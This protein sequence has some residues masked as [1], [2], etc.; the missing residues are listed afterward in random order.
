MPRR[1]NNVKKIS[2]NNSKKKHFEDDIFYAES[3]YDEKGRNRKDYYNSIS[4]MD[5]E[6]NF[7]LES[8]LGHKNC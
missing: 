7:N 5:S 1:N 6:D 4:S 2:K 3:H 8:L